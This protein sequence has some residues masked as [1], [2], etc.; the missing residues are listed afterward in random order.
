MATFYAHSLE[1]DPDPTHWQDLEAHLNG[2]ADRAGKFAEFFE[3]RG[4]GHLD[5]LR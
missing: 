3:S 4:S 2:V 5:S 1:N